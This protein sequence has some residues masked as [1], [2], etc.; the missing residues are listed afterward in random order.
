MLRVAPD[1]RET[2]AARKVDDQSRRLRRVRADDL[3]ADV[4]LLE[5]LAPRDEG[6]QQQV[7][8]RPVVEQQ[9]AQGVAVDRDVAHRLRDDRRHE[10]RLARQQVQLAQKAGWAVADD[11]VPGRVQDRRLALQ[12]CDERIALVPDPIQNVTNRRRSLLS[13]CC[14]RRQLGRRQ[15]RAN[16]ARHLQSVPALQRAPRPVVVDG[17][18]SALRP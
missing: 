12:N 7:G 10:H 16:G 11:L 13:E 14:E 6:R 5:R 4:P 17:P 18:S 15:D 1:K 8:E 9:R 2:I 3:H